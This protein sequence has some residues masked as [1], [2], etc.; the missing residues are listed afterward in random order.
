MCTKF[1]NIEKYTDIVRIYFILL[2]ADS[3][4]SQQHTSTIINVPQVVLVLC[5]IQLISAIIFSTFMS[6]NFSG[7]VKK[8][9]L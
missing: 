2:E 4:C 7:L 8:K 3:L 6:I 9:I 5:K 1:L